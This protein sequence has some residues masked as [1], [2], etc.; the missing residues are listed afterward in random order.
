MRWPRK[1]LGPCH[2]FFGCQREDLDFL[3]AEELTLTLS[4]SLTLIPLTLTL[5]QPPP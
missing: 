4:L 3:Y 1:K 5:I 2:L